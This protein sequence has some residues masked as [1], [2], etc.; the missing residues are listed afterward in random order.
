MAE[1]EGFEPSVPRL[2]AHAISSRAPSAN[3]D[4]SPDML[5]CRSEPADHPTARSK[6]N[7]CPAVVPVRSG[8]MFLHHH[9]ALGTFLVAHPPAYLV[10]QRAVDFLAERVGFEPTCPAFNG[11]SRFRVD[12]VTTT[13][14]PLR[15]RCPLRK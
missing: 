15:E 10:N 12:P 4:I 11:T 3:S 13:S 6:Y 5:F 9:A 2:A 1:R 8:P 14:V 7:D